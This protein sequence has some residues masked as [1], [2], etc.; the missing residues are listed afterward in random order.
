MNALIVAATCTTAGSALVS[1]SSRTGTNTWRATYRGMMPDYVLDSLG[2][3]GSRRR[4]MMAHL[5]PGQFVLVAEHD[6]E[7]VGFVNGGRSRVEDAAHPGEIY[8]IYVLPS[9]HGHGHGAALM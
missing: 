4:Q 3:D 1:S 8:A 9:H 2:Y 5:H 6:G 7:V